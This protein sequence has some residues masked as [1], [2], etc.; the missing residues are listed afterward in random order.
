VAE[1]HASSGNLFLIE[2]PNERTCPG[3]ESGGLISPDALQ[4]RSISRSD[5]FAVQKDGSAPP[6]GFFRSLAESAR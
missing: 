2:A 6:D 5:F 3:K 4:T 1:F